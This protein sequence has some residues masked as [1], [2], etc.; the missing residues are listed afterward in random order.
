MTM[1]AVTAVPWL[2]IV[3]YDSDPRWLV[4]AVAS[5][6]VGHVASTGS[7]YVDPE[8]RPL[9]EAEPRRM[10]LVPGLVVCAAVVLTVA[11]GRTV[12]ELVLGG[13]AVWTVH[14]FTKQNA[15]VVSFV[16]KARGTD[17]LTPLERQLMSATTVAAVLALSPLI[18]PFGDPI[19]D[20]AALRWVGVGGLLVLAPILGAVG[21][22]GDPVRAAALAG[23]AV[24]YWPLFLCTS[25]FA[26]TAAYS[27]A[28]GLQY[29]VM[30]SH[31]R[32]G[33]DPR[34]HRAQ[35]GRFVG[36]AVAGGVALFWLTQQYPGAT[37][38]PWAF[39][40]YQ[41]IVVCHFLSDGVFWRLSEPFQR[42]YMAKR[43]AFL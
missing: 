8:M 26:A 21:W 13:L 4:L 37:S 11:G 6:A 18:R 25:L 24:F 40:L 19:V 39:G 14:H 35:L 9:V 43:F 23:C 33:R 38:H 1:L 28:H 5:V 7:M 10:V 3:L 2:L 20:V 34:G 15:G 30:C 29:L 17:R 32:H 42:G 12:V 36:F 41:G 16:C 27:M 22:R 31:V